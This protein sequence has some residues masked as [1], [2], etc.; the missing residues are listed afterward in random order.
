MVKKKTRTVPKEGPAEPDP[1]ALAREVVRHLDQT[2]L[3]CMCGREISSTTV[4]AIVDAV[5]YSLTSERGSLTV[6][7]SALRSSLSSHHR[8]EIDRQM[9]EIRMVIKP[10]IT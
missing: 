9:D 2:C 8:A 7:D 6:A 4:P 5:S 1:L 3:R 10:A